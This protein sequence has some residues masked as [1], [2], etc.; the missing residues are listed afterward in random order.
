MILQNRNQTFL[1][2]TLFGMTDNLFVHQA[3]NG[4]REFQPKLSTW[5][6]GLS[7][8]TLSQTRVEQNQIPDLVH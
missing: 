4:Y 2:S 1:Y 5:I 3:S 8:V 6:S 7:K